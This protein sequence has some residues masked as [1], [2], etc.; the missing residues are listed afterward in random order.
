MDKKLTVQNEL[1]KLLQ[2]GYK[3]QEE[4]NAFQIH[5]VSRS[6][7]PGFTNKSF[8][9]YLRFGANGHIDYKTFT[10]SINDMF[11]KFGL[12]LTKFVSR[13]E[14]I[15]SK[16]E[17]DSPAGL[18][19]RQLRE[20]ENIT[21]ES[22]IFESFILPVTHE[23]VEFIDGVVRQGFAQHK[24][25]ENKHRALIRNLWDMRRIETPNGKLLRKDT[26]TK[27]DNIYKKLEVDHD[28]FKD[29]VRAIKIE[30]KRKNIDL[31]IKF[32]KDVVLIVT[33]DSM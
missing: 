21:T 30:M 1:K 19:T 32:P 33:Q 13:T 26:P 17:P 12:N 10:N 8:S 7:E 18:L 16:I 11:T 15:N 4:K 31:D 3:L 25:R 29:I 14:T 28:R 24:F 2:A 27:R 6:W 22:K 23:R 5:R 9:D 20:L